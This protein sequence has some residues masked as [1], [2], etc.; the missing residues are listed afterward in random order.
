M[1]DQTVPNPAALPAPSGALPV[2]ACAATNDLAGRPPACAPADR[3]K[4]SEKRGLD[5]PRCGCKHF[6]VLYTRAVLGGRI[7][8]RRECRHCGRRITTHEVSL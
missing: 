8:R 6:H 2:P 7:R 1:S 4:L 3:L 5:C